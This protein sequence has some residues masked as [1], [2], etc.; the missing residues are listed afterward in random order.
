ML[1]Q[2]IQVTKKEGNDYPPLPKDVYQAELLDITSE[3][4]PTFDT[5][6]LSEAEKIYETVMSFQFTLLNGQEGDQSLRC[7]NVWA[8]F[9][10][11]YLYISKKSGKN[12]LYRIIESLIGHELSPQEE[13]ELDQNFLNSLVGKQCRVSVEP[14]QSGDRTFDNI[15]DW[16]KSNGDLVGLNNEEKEKCRV[17][18]EVQ[19]IA[20]QVGGEVVP[21]PQE[22]MSTPVNPGDKGIDVET[23]P[24]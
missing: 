21:P 2:Q 5:K 13:A 15:T 24:F 22:D 3:Q 1:E 20:Q 7:R 10:P 18:K 4:K 23:I 14:K 11:T 6:N 8:N 17:K 19:D 16:L 9:I 12:K